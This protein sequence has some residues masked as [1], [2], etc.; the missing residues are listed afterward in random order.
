MAAATWHIKWQPF[1]TVVAALVSHHDSRGHSQWE[2]KDW[3]GHPWSYLFCVTWCQTWWKMCQTCFR[4]PFLLQLMF[5]KALTCGVTCWVCIFA[6]DIK[7]ATQAPYLLRISWRLNWKHG[8]SW[9]YVPALT[10]MLH[11]KWGRMTRRGKR[12]RKKIECILA[13]DD[14]NTKRVYE[15]TVC[16]KL[17]REKYWVQLRWWKVFFGLVRLLVGLDSFPPSVWS[18]ALRKGFKYGQNIVPMSEYD[19]AALPPGCMQPTVLRS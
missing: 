12:W 2:P 14:T 1:S 7:R 5:F 10:S 4:L 11:L 15:R 3:Q 13:A 19:E 8:S 18:S 6:R 17:A 9:K 16:D